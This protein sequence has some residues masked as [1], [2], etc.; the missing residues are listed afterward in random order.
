[1]IKMADA[2]NEPEAAKTLFQLQKAYQGALAKQDLKFNHPKPA[3]NVFK[4]R[5]LGKILKIHKK[6][7]I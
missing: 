1:M 7:I 5:K 2:Q 3:N 4:Q 6:G